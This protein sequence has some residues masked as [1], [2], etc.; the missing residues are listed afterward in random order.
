MKYLSPELFLNNSA[1][2]VILDVR[3]PEEYNQGHIPEAVSF[4]LF[5]DDERRRV[6][7]RYKNSGKL[8]AINLG[9]DLVGP[10]M[11]SFVSQADYKFK[12][13]NLFIHCWRGG[14]RSES[15]GWLF[16][17]AGF[18]VF[19]LEGGYKAYRACVRKSWSVPAK[20]LILGGYTGSGK[21]EVLNI[22]ESAGEQVL[23]LEKSARHKG[24][25]FGDLGMEGQPTNEQFENN[26]HSKWSRFNKNKNIWIEDESRGI[27]TV[28]IPEPLFLTMKKSPLIFIEID[29][30][31]RIERLVNEYSLFDKSLLEAAILRISRRLGGLNTKL[32]VEN[33]LNGNYHIVASVLLSYYDK[34]YMNNLSSRD[35]DKIIN[36]VFHS[37]EIDKIADK[38]IRFS[39]HFQNEVWKNKFSVQTILN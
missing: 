18:S 37:A 14:M 2:H 36:L 12:G 25:A 28:S 24:S 7:L 15:M 31:S 4:P 20:L 34:A 32:A 11:S 29:K 22:L 26:I 16:E 33:L 39:S 10:K 23:D 19:V 17:K 6:G 3:S 5:D 8:S 35:A 9:L 27:G 1:G 13:H 21:S 38:L 30:N